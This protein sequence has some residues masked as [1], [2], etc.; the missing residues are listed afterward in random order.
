[1]AHCQE[2]YDAV[3]Q[4]ALVEVPEAHALLEARLIA[5]MNCDMEHEMQ[6]ESSG[7]DQSRRMEIR[8]SELKHSM[9]VI[10]EHTARIA[11]I[12]AQTKRKGE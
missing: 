1:M 6:A 5:A 12:A 11:R 8:H 2:F 9:K 10:Q 4:S 3:A 7:L